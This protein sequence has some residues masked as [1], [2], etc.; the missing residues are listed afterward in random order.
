M[1]TLIIFLVKVWS[2]LQENKPVMSNLPLLNKRKQPISSA[3]LNDLTPKSSRE[4]NNE[5]ESDS[6]PVRPATAQSG[7]LLLLLIAASASCIALVCG[8]LIGYVLKA[9]YSKKLLKRFDHLVRKTANCHA[10]AS[11][12][13]RTG[14]SSTSD[15]NQFKSGL[16]EHRQSLE[17]DI[18]QSIMH[19]M[20]NPMDKDIECATSSD[21]SAINSISCNTSPNTEN[22]SK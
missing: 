12:L 14:S 17:N 7:L 16:V 6:L 21:D 10:N 1:H 18:N 15:A 5:T 3:F 20:Y 8:I 2:M 22:N 13:T 9:K 4:E 19:K 11:S